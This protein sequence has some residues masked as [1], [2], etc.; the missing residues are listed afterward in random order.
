M[1]D[2]RLDIPKDAVAAVCRKYQ[3]REPSLFGSALRDDFRPDSDLD[4]L[5]SFQPEARVGFVTLARLARELSAVLD[6]KV[7]LVPKEGLKRAIRAEVLAE[8]EVL[9]A[10]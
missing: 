7:D 4:L 5:V 1:G 9:F 3:V 8:A 10:A 6:R 2:L